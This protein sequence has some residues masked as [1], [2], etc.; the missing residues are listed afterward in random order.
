MTRPQ[1]A[2]QIPAGPNA[3][4]D[5]GQQKTP[6]RHRAPSGA[7]IALAAF[8]TRPQ[9]E[10]SNRRRTQISSAAQSCQLTIRPETIRPALRAPLPALT[11]SLRPPLIRGQ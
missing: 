8:I 5:Q 6:L 11:E 4:P 1:A 10:C 3:A 7:R 9:A 2:L